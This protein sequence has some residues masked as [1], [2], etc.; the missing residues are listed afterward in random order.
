MPDNT[1]SFNQKGRN[2][3]EALALFRDS[4]EALRLKAEPG[5]G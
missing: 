5:F 2:R 3:A 4:N 1:D